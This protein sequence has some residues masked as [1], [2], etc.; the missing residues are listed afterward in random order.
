MTSKAGAPTQI[1]K[2]PP[3]EAALGMSLQEELIAAIRG[4]EVEL[5]E[6]GLTTPL[7]TSGLFD[8]SALFNLVLWVE[9]KIG[10]PVDPT[11]FDLVKEWDTV[12]DVVSFIGKNRR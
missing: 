12:T 7:V 9:E 11:T 2:I 1:T 5:P 8:S 3:N 4:W 10:T 6:V